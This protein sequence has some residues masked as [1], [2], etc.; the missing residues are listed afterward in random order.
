MPRFCV[1]AEFELDAA[2]REEAQSNASVALEY[3]RLATGAIPCDGI[4][5]PEGWVTVEEVKP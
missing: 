3:Y 4:G 1:K 5:C 2:S